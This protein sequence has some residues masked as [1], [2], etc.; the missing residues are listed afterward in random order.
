MK[1]N[2][3]EKLYKKLISIRLSQ[4]CLI[5]QYH[6]EDL[7]RCP[8]HFC[9]GQE[10]LATAL[11]QIFK[12]NDYVLSH[13]RSHAYYLSKNCPMDRM[14]YEFYGR[15]SGTSMGLSGSQEL[16]YDPG[17]F[18]SGTIL[19]GMFAI[20]LGTAYSQKN[21]SKK[22]NITFTI[23][24]D[25]G[26][27]EGICFET[28]NL[29]SYHNLPIV[30]ICENN[31]YSVHTNILERSKNISY[32]DKVKSFNIK[33]HYFDTQNVLNLYK[34]V[35]QIVNEVRKTKKPCFIEFDTMRHCGHVGPENDDE[36]Y[37]Y[38]KQDLKKWGNVDCVSIFENQLNNKFIANIRKNEKA[39]ILKI[40][41]KAKKQKFLDFN[42]SLKLNFI[43]SYSNKI[44]NFSV[45][46]I[47]YI[48]KQ[49]ETK[50]EP[51]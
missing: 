36:A 24:G 49:K 38:R 51:Y 4:E 2:L 31:R 29:A 45:D 20:S 41:K 12:K 43:E 28:L 30:F 1:K 44:K 34:N 21:F 11:S 16:S 23:I 9:L 6:P 10:A 8:I 39:K 18:Y 27:E 17:K 40:I 25:G 5:S 32:K 33:Y 26:M 46:K 13:H 37:N 42:Q 35:I 14:I 22:N 19:S 7:M 47:D 15:A 3:K 48:S 50:L